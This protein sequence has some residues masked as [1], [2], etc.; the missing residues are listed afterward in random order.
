MRREAVQDERNRGRDSAAGGATGGGGADADATVASP[1]GAVSEDP[2]NGGAGGDTAGNAATNG[3][4]E[5]GMDG[6]KQGFVFERLARDPRFD[7]VTRRHGYS[8]GPIGLLQ[9][10]K[11]GMEGMS[12][13]IGLLSKKKGL[14]GTLSPTESPKC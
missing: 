9:L 2:S 14:L 8:R 13:L 1:A 5:S 7:N 4:G 11:E 6:G 12:F 10:A 3:N